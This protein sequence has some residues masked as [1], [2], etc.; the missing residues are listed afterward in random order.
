MRWL[1]VLVLLSACGGEAPCADCAD[2][3]APDGGDPNAVVAIRIEPSALELEVVDGAADSGRFEAF[4]VEADGDSRPAEGIEWSLGRRD[5]VAID[6]AGAVSS[7]SDRGGESTVFARAAMG[8]LALE[9]RATVSVRVVRTFG[10]SDARLDG[11][12]ATDAGAAPIVLYPL[13][14]AVMPRNLRPPVVQWRPASGE[15]DVYRVRLE[16]P[17]ARVVATLTNTGAGFSHAW[18]VDPEAWR[19]LLE[20]DPDAEIA[21]DVDRWQASRE[22]A[23]RGASTV[24]MRVARGVV[25]GEVYYWALDRGRIYAVDPETATPRDVVPSPPP[26]GDGHRCIACHTVSR[27][28]RWLFGRRFDDNAGFVIDL[29]EDT[30]TD[31]PPMRYAPASGIETA[32]FDPSGER[33]LAAGPDG[34]LFIAD[35]A[36]GLALGSAGLPTERAS[37]PAWSPS[38]ALVAWIEATAL[39]DAEAPTLLRLARAEGELAFGAPSVL[40]RGSDAAGAE[41]GSVDALPSFTPDDRFVVFQHGPTAFTTGNAAPRGALY[42]ASTDGGAVWRLDAASEGHAFWPTASPYVTT[43]PG[44]RYFWIAFHSRRDYG[45]AL[46]GTWGRRTRQLW[47][48]AVDAD[49]DDG[50]DPSFAPVWL[51]GQEAAVDNVAAYWAPE[52][53]RTEGQSCVD[54]GEC[55]GGACVDGAEG[56]V[57][58]APPG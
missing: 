42:L 25:G 37:M 48:A 51:P 58:A 55:C 57:C 40:H 22:R 39:G 47:I 56:R 34:A 44:G 29:A 27:D 2:A 11:E 3:S 5:I 31:P 26:Q 17:H 6:P 28:G 53:C 46:A 32:A 30:T 18:P 1:S 38:G 50:V 14:G 16:T 19:V 54:D 15:G 24:R 9:G 52:P 20:T 45:N 4:F 36:S 23:V 43:E 33:L 12:L 21:I 8:T 41:G 35:A 7:D 10:G 49:P 13:D